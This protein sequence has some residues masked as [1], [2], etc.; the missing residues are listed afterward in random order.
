MISLYVGNLSWATTE[1][2][3]SEFFSAFGQVTSAEVVTD[4]ETGR[5]RGFGYVKYAD[6][7]EAE[8]AAT[9]AN[10]AELDGRVLCV[11][12]AVARPHSRFR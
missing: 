8:R 1:D 4:R 2:K 12:A 5:S 10:G 6:D 11:A 9:Q 7:N 3:L